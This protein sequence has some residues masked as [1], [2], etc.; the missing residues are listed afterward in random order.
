M[1]QSRLFAS[2]PMAE[3]TNSSP[4]RRATTSSGPTTPCNLRATSFGRVSPAPCPGKSLTSLKR[5][6][7]SIRMPMGGPG[8]ASPLPLQRSRQRD[9]LLARPVRH[10]DSPLGNACFVL[11][12]S[13]HVLVGGDPAAIGHRPIADAEEAAVCELDNGVGRLDV[14]GNR[15]WPNPD[16]HC[17]II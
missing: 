10:R 12:R 7:S 2:T 4:P 8:R 11:F 6:R 14:N 15:I 5:S 1:T 3:V 16:S 9:D 17:G 13:C